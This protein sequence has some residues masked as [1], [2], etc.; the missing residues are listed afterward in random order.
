[1]QHKRRTGSFSVTPMFGRR[2]GANGGLLLAAEA[3]GLSGFPH[4]HSIEAEVRN[5]DGRALSQTTVRVLRS[6]FQTSNL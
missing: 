5:R 6:N 2:M 4:L 3:S 1:M